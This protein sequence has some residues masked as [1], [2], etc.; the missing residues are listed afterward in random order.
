MAQKKKERVRQMIVAAARRE[1]AEVGIEGATLTHIA[2]RAE[3]SVGN[4]YK[5]FPGK[6]ALFNA[7]IPAVLVQELD[8]LVRRRV[9][10]LGAARDVDILGPDHPYRS[11]AEELLDFSVVHRDV[12][13][14]LLRRA[15]GSPFESFGES[16]ARSL[17]R[18][19]S[20]Y[21]ERAWPGVRL[22]AGRRRVLLRL[23]RAFLASLASILDEE[24]SERAVR[25]ATVALTTYHLAGLR[26][27][28]ATARPAAEGRLE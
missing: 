10:S 27:F 18:M 16:L 23:Y 19:A 25:E 1:F 4:L 17:V 5:Y 9:E 2:A 12:L 6:E 28:L 7:A 15:G 24:S 21:G 8:G 13:R 20:R 26:A 22:T 14:F 3:T 11:A